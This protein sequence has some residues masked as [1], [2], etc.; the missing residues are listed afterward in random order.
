MGGRASEKMEG[1][2]SSDVGFTWGRRMK[3]FVH[4]TRATLRRSSTKSQRSR[5]F[6]FQRHD[7]KTNV[8]T[9]QKGEIAT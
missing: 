1:F 4:K 6:I 5:G 7:V 3:A 9:F 8:V 2:E